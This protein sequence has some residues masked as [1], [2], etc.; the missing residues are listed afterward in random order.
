MHH[1]LLII[2]LFA[3]T[4]WIGGHLI[5]SIGFLPDALKKKD[6]S[7]ITNFEKS[8]EKIGLPALLLLII[9]GILLSYNY[10]VIVSDWFSFK[11]SIER[12]VSIKLLLLFSTLF[13]A[14]HARIFI[15][16]KLNAKLLP[17]MAFHIILITLIGLSMMV[18]GTFVRFGG[19]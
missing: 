13:L 17:F 6:P 10:N 18:V 2:H 1:L 14:V 16:P 9:T 3:A 7:I 8:Y 5:L 4:I 11:S 15:I 12:V 19:I